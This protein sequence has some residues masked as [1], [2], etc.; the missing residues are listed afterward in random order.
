M[1]V[2]EDVLKFISDSWSWLSY[3]LLGFSGRLAFDIMRGKKITI[4]KTLASFIIA[5]FV[6]RVTYSICI[7]QGLVED[8]SAIGSIA[9]LLSYDIMKAIFRINVKGIILDWA[10]NAISKIQDNGKNK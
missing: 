6:G 5:V 1:K 8:V 9:C 2:G 3:T 10:Q 4:I 7:A